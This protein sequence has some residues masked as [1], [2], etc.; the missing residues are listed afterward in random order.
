MSGR[1][2]VI[3]EDNIGRP[4]ERPGLP[5]IE[6]K[7][8]TIMRV[9]I[10]AMLIVLGTSAADAHAYLKH[11]S[12]AAGSTVR[13]APKELTMWFTEGLEPAFSRAEVRNAKGA[14]VDR[15][16][17][18]VV[19]SHNTELQIGLKP[20]PPGS[21]KVSWHVMSVDTHKTHGTFSFNVA[22]H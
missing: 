11:A 19:S 2:H 3:I 18:H 7:G 21:Y 16:K 14:R 5:D 15:G 9:I 8:I 17:A 1:F 10:A 13:H 12:P 6:S 4:F 20:L 22:G